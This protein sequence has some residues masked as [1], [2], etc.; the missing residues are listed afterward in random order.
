MGP[1]PPDRLTDDQLRALVEQ[2]QNLCARL[3][4]EG[5][6]ALIA[7]TVLSLRRLSE[8]LRKSFQPVSDRDQA[9]LD[10][11]REGLERMIRSLR[12]AQGAGGLPAPSPEAQAEIVVDAILRAWILEGY[13]G[14]PA[15]IRVLF[16][17]RHLAPIQRGIRVLLPALID[18]GIVTRA[19]AMDFLGVLLDH[20]GEGQWSRLRRW[21]PLRGPMG[22]W[23]QRVAWQK[24]WDAYQG[25]RREPRPLP[26][27]E[28][29]RPSE[30]RWKPPL[31]P[32]AELTLLDS[33][34]LV[35]ELIE[36]W[37]DQGRDEADLWIL[38]QAYLEEWTDEQIARV[39]GVRRETVNRRKQR[40][41]RQA[42]C[43]LWNRYSAHALE[44]AP[45]ADLLNRAVTMYCEGA[46]IDRIASALGLSPEEVEDLLREAMER[47][48]RS[49][50]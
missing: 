48:F 33:Q 5:E 36:M 8:R 14:F 6:Q 26:E 40:A 47:L 12:A 10:R 9:D 45:Q 27:N 13:P 18:C 38:L 43:L 17:D 46:S 3:F 4:P 42:F 1:P 16:L 39:L 20:L 28:A 2:T 31:D 32:E 24:A 15:A 7:A 50:T 44:N 37:R 22:P 35:K 19:D 25:C 34:R 41:L 30:E 21:D 49:L 29:E 11:L 23:L